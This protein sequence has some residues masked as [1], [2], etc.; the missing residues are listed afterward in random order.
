[1][2][3]EFRKQQDSRNSQNDVEKRKI[4]E[5]IDRLQVLQNTLKEMQKHQQEEITQQKMSHLRKEEEFDIKN[6]EIMIEL[7]NE[8]HALSLERE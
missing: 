4:K 1:M 7:E 5:E 6:K 2:M 8:R 3:Q